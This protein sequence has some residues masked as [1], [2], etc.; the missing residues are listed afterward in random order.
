MAKTAKQQAIKD[1]QED[2]QE[3][4]KSFIAFYTELN[5]IMEKLVYRHIKAQR[6]KAS[7]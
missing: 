3:Q 4:H 6:K 1:I 2:L 5:P 7:K